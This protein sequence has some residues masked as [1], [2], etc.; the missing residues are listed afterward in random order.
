SRARIRQHTTLNKDERAVLRATRQHA[1]ENYQKAIREIS[2][3][4]EEKIATV[5]QAHRKNVKRVRANVHMAPQVSLKRH[6]RQNS[7]NA[8]TWM[9]AKKEKENIGTENVRKTGKDVLPD[10]VTRNKDEYA[11][12]TQ[13]VKDDLVKGL[14][15]AKTTKAKGFQPS[16]RSRIN[17]VT[18]TLRVLENEIAN[19]RSRTGIEALLFITRGTSSTPINGVS[20]ATPGVD[21]F[22]ESGLKV[23]EHEFIA[24]MEGFALQGLKGSTT[25]NYKQEIS[26]KR[27]AIRTEIIEQLRNITGDE[28]AQMEWKHYWR[29]VVAYH[30]VMI[31][32]WPDNIPFKNLSEASSALPELK[33]LLEQWQDGRIHW[34]H[35]TDD[36][37]ERVVAE[38]KAQGKVPEVARRTQSDRG[39]KR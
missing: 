28:S 31:E 6:S 33:K 32:G 13:E 7:W 1:S 21:K 27:T 20:Y 14:E 38:H 17:D 25:S 2:S 37:A 15:M 5:A 39:K 30:K 4:I 29:K 11:T 9:Q 19:L 24:K 22:L 36:E 35:L 3:I 26:K 12:L 10:I 18:T 23:D 8:F 34:K 16:A